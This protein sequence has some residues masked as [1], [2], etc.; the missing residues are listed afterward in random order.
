M[1]C[2]RVVERDEEG[3]SIRRVS[4]DQARLVKAHLTTAGA[5]L[6][7]EGLEGEAVHG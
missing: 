7:E 1:D 6:R 2:I 3:T 4:P 5:L